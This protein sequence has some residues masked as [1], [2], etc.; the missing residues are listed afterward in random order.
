MAK[1]GTAGGVVLH[2][3]HR[4]GYEIDTGS[5]KRKLGAMRLAL[6]VPLVLRD[7]IDDADDGR[8]RRAA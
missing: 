6:L 8:E 2:Y 1:I 3:W 4:R 5:I 7:K